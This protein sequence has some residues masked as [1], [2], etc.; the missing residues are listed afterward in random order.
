MDKAIREALI[1]DDSIA[2]QLDLTFA[3]A[4]QQ[5]TIK[6]KLEIDTNPPAQSGEA[7]TFLD[8]PADYEARHQD[9][10]SNFPLKIHALLCRGYPQG[11]R[12]VR[13]LVVRLTRGIS[14]SVAPSADSPSGRSVGKATQVE[15]GRGLAAKRANARDQ[16]D[17]LAQ[18]RQ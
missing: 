18:G 5:K 17:R 13:L 11:T 4:R 7:T 15:C 16:F 2:S 8:F 10:A 12:L 3:D 6:I 14:Q 1:K 9:L